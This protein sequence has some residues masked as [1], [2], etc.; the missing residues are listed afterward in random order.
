MSSARAQD[1]AENVIACVS[2]DGARRHCEGYTDAGVALRESIGSSTCLLGRN[3][4]N[5]AAGVWVTEGCGARFV[6]GN[7]SAEEQRVAAATRGTTTG[8]PD[9][10]AAGARQSLGDYRVYSRFGAQTAFTQDEAQVQD[11]GSRIGFEYSVGDEIRLFAAGEWSLRLTGNENPFYPGDTTSSGFVLLE[12]RGTDVFGSRLGY[13]GV[14]FNE[15][16]RFALGKQWGVHYDVTSYTDRFNVFGADASATFNANTDGGLMGTG[17]ADSALSYRNTLFDRLEIGAQIQMRD[18]SN[19]E[20]VDGYGASVQ[21]KII[22]GLKA[23]A[24][25]T[26]VKFDERFTG[27]LLGLD[28]DGEYLALG[29]RYD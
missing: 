22:E 9:T 28:G 20:A 21:V 15:W 14:D 12:D 27:A 3:W 7:P 2:V 16:G 11:A 17:R 23:G 24:S 25:Y 8:N 19:G 18:L 4:G 29:L 13:V 1:S 5:D 26:R 10:T 6:L